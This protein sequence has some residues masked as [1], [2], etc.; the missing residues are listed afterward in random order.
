MPGR[1]SLFLKDLNMQA[2]VEITSQAIL[3]MHCTMSCRLMA[4]LTADR[5]RFCSC[6]RL[7]CTQDRCL[8][9]QFR[10]DRYVRLE[11]NKCSADSPAS[12]RRV[13]GIAER[14]EV[15]PMLGI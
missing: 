13:P 6:Q 14:R 2:S 3:Q 7:T 4:C 1:Y 5:P 11:L 12:G 15:T 9:S 8:R 10:W